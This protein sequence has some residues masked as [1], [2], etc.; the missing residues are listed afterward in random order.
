MSMSVRCE[1]CGLEYAGARG[2]GGLFAAGVEPGPAR[3]PADARRGHGASTGTPVALA[4]AGRLR[5]RRRRRRRHARRVPG[6]RRLLA[7]LRRAL[8]AAGRRLRV[9]GGRDGVARVPG[10]LPVRVP[11]TTTG[12]SPS[13]ARRRGARSSAGRGSYVE[14]G[15]KELAAVAVSTPVRA[16]TRHRRRR[17]DPRRR[18]HRRTAPTRSWSPPTPT[19]RCALLAD[20]TADE[21]RA[22]GRVPLLAQ[23]HPA[24]HRRLGAA[25]PARRPGVLELPDG[26]LRGSA[27]RRC[28]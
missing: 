21:T 14:R 28:S 11:A 23:R 26:H 5:R 3:L 17:R 19:R 7:L 15:R 6:R 2:L 1:G 10:P 24:A 9:V 12:C 22:A 20:P 25:A 4:S 18:R 27:T 16:L 8:H 13:P